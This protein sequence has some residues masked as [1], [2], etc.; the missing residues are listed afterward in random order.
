MSGN[1]S[2][3]IMHQQTDLN[4]GKSSK[5]DEVKELFAKNF[6][7]KAYT[8]VDDAKWFGPINVPI[9]EVDWDASKSWATAH[10]ESKVQKFKADIEAGNPP[11][12]AVMVRQPGDPKYKIV[13]GHHRTTAYKQLG[14]DTAPAYV[15]LVDDDDDRWEETHSFQTHQGASP[16]NKKYNPD[17]PRGAGGR[18]IG[19]GG[20]EHEGG[21]GGGG[22]EEESETG[23]EKGSVF[24]GSKD[25][26]GETI[27]HPVH[28]EGTITAADKDN[29]TV[30]YGDGT[31]RQYAA[32]YAA[33]N[34]KLVDTGTTE[35]K[36]HIANVKVGKDGAVTN[37]DDGKTVGHVSKAA[38]GSW[39]YTHTDGTTESGFSSKHT[40]TRGLIGHHNDTAAERMAAKQKPVEKPTETPKPK[41]IEELKPASK[42][43]AKP[44]KL[45]PVSKRTDLTT[46]EKTAI[47]EWVHGGYN[48]INKVLRNQGVDKLTEAQIVKANDQ[49]EHIDSAM[50][51][52][53]L[54]N[55]VVLHRGLTTGK[56]LPDG[57]DEVGSTFHDSGYMATSLDD[58]HGTMFEN[59]NHLMISVPAGSHGLFISKSP[60]NEVLLPRGSTLHVDK[61]ETSTNNYGHEIKI[62]HAHLVSG[63]GS[64]VEPVPTPETHETPDEAPLPEDHASVAEAKPK[65]T[66]PE[67]SEAKPAEESTAKPV[68]EVAAEASKQM[69]K[70]QVFYHGSRANLKVGDY[71]E[72]GHESASNLQDNSKVYFTPR[73]TKA[74]SYAVN[75]STK[76]KPRVY[77]VIPTGDYG[78]D[79]ADTHGLRSSQRLLIVKVHDV[80][81][82]YHFSTSDYALNNLKRSTFNVSFKPGTHIGHDSDYDA[83]SAWLEAK[84]YGDEDY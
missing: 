55:D 56:P 58:P 28:G 52:S 46:D 5:A 23:N 8:W 79:P 36:T 51:K 2:D 63:E 48:N 44:A 34:P 42:P 39:Q 67:E 74:E 62:I 66:A 13:D 70:T 7:P 16:A 69:Y 50:S 45:V 65:E 14:K 64:S 24:V 33:Q 32:S 61:V 35:G 10:Q 80:P 37:R 83:D 75:A 72:P 26:V 77:E 22:G 53:T 49:I 15:G 12:P 17:E 25:S 4:V 73:A 29:V 18:W 81:N 60:Y 59:Y 47:N 82:K 84:W 76:G 1:A 68:G 6:P 21:G 71:I 43:S 20:H 38:D 3:L 40:A 9:D 11:R 31:T 30:Q 57:L 78:D 54:P 27:S 19:G 41:P